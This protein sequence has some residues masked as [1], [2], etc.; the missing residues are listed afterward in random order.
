MARLMSLFVFLLAPTALA[1]G[2]PPSLLTAAPPQLL[3]GLEKD[4]AV[5][6]AAMDDYSIKMEACYDGPQG[7]LELALHI[8]AANLLRPISPPCAAWP[9]IRCAMMSLIMRRCYH[10]RFSDI[11]AMQVAAAYATA[12]GAL[13][14]AVRHI[15]AEDKKQA[16]DLAGKAML[17]LTFE[18]KHPYFGATRHVW[19]GDMQIEGG[20]L[21]E[22]V[23]DL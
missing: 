7:P 9:K 1:C 22:A 5:F 14:A 23:G 21:A 12:W 8:K 18:F 16:L 6:L 20:C 17:Q 2:A 19:F 10:P 4:S 13:A 15:S 11:E 3:R